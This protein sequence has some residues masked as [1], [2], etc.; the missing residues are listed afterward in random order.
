MIIDNDINE[1]I[2]KLESSNRLKFI[3]ELPPSEQLLIHY[4]DVSDQ[5]TKV[6]FLLFTMDND[7][8]V[9]IRYRASQA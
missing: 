9:V 6:T 1:F 7:I 2:Q 4:N 8:P 3:E 5:D